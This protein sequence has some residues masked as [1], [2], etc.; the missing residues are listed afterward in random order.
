MLTSKEASYSVCERKTVANWQEKIGH[1][2]R[3]SSFRRLKIS[4]V[5]VWCVN[6][7][8]KVRLCV[9]KYGTVAIVPTPNLMCS[10]L[11]DSNASCRSLNLTCGFTKSLW[12]FETFI[13]TKF[14]CPQKTW[15]TDLFQS[16]ALLNQYILIRFQSHRSMS[17]FA[18]HCQC[19]YPQFK[20]MVNATS[21]SASWICPCSFLGNSWVWKL[22]TGE[23]VIF[24]WLM[25]ITGSQ[26][27]TLET[28]TL[29]VG[30][31]LTPP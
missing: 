20:L 18:M 14:D 26:M 29:T 12:S 7:N 2:T 16:I 6:V 10:M 8:C 24:G 31:T 25:V 27:S 19:K 28:L 23:I 3:L 5:I 4:E 17:S 1:N 9:H 13:F 21:I 22:I 30:L 15:T 11:P